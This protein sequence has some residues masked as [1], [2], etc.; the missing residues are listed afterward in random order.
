M[1]AD[2]D[3]LAEEGD[4]FGLFSARAVGTNINPQTLLATDYLNHFN[5]IVMLLGMIP[6]IPDCFEEAQAWKSKGYQEHF[7]DSQF[8]DRE[9]AIE[10]YEYVPAPYRIAFEDTVGQMNAVVFQTLARIAEALQGGDQIALRE[11]CAEASRTLQKMIDVAS[12]IIHGS[13]RTLGQAEIDG[14]LAV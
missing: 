7:R 6:D 9:F 13:T 1:T 10:A 8:H 3:G 4:K 5:E 12:A 2:G 14:V 11:A